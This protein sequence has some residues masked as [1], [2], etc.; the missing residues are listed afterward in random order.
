MT[1]ADNKETAAP[2]D[3][4]FAG[5]ANSIGT[6]N[7]WIVILTM[8]AVFLVI[9]AAIIAVFGRPGADKAPP[10]EVAA[11]VEETVAAPEPEALPEGIAVPQGAAPGAIALDGDR[12]AVRLDG[13]DGVEIVVYDLAK[14]EIV[15]RVPFRT[16]ERSASD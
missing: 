8:P 11:P 5:L 14:G 12:L 10:A 1:D 4:G 15:A 6:R 9:V 2:A 3:A 7:L 13:P 16:A